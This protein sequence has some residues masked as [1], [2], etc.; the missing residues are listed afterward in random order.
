ML[1]YKSQDGEIYYAKTSKQNW[2]K[3]P[4]VQHLGPYYKIQPHHS[5]WYSFF[6]DTWLPL[7]P[8][9]PMNLIE[10]VISTIEGADFDVDSSCERNSDHETTAS[11][12]GIRWKDRDRVFFEVFNL[13]TA[14]IKIHGEE[15]VVVPHIVDKLFTL[16]PLCP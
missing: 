3:K 15:S 4:L 8:E 10:D 16:E 6:D 2:N 1:Y 5:I 12:E 11:V 9:H 13:I 14:W 7:P